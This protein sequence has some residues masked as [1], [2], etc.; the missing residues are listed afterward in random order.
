MMGDKD[1]RQFITTA[2]E[3][4][5]REID[6]AIDATDITKIHVHEVTR[7]LRRSYYDRDSPLDSPP[8]AFSDLVAGMLRRLGYAP[9]EVTYDVGGVSLVGRADMV[10][11][12][13]VIIFRPADPPPKIPIA[14]DLLAL[15]SYMWMHDKA[16]GVIVYISADRT[17]T[18]FSL[19]RDKRMFE[20]TIRRVR[21]LGDLLAEGKRLPIIEPSPECASCQ[22]Y[23]R[24]FAKQRIGRPIRLISDILGHNPDA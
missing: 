11:E 24:C 1:Y 14:G 8:R 23:E 18:S 15:N 10:V 13:T 17:E 9:D 19:T 21:V 16:D 2:L 5:S 20:E 12:D 6:P 22:Y 4:I 3:S 7:C